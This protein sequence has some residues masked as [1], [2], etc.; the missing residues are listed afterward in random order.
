MHGRVANPIRHCC[1][2]YCLNSRHFLSRRCHFG[3]NYRMQLQE[4]KIYLFGFSIVYFAMR[5]VLDLH[6]NFSA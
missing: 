3:V 5:P 1:C 4:M 2:A 6:A